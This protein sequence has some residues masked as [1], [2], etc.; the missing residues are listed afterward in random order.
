M[1]SKNKISHLLKSG[2]AM[3][4][5]LLYIG[6]Y[7][8][9]HF[10]HSHV[11]HDHHE[12]NCSDTVRLDA[13]HLAVY[14]HGEKGACDHPFHMVETEQSCELCKA[15]VVLQSD[16]VQEKTTW[17]TFSIAKTQ[18]I[19]YTSPKLAFKRSHSSPRAPPALHL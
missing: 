12:A 19:N 15:I 18:V 4:F 13:C 10:V 8:S 6:V 11:H 3:L 14:H 9:Q 1:L 16:F 7:F 2:S 17:L 5:L